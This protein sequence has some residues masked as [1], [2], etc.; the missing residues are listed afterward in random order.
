LHRDN[1]TLISILSCHRLLVVGVACA[2]T[3]CSD[4]GIADPGNGVLTTDWAC[5]GHEGDIVVPANA[6]RTDTLTLR[7]PTA[8]DSQSKRYIGVL[9]GT[10]RVSYGGQTSNT[11]TQMPPAGIAP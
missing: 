1:F 3:A 5:V 4:A 7:G 10:F 9:A 6:V 8:Y 11:F 2:I